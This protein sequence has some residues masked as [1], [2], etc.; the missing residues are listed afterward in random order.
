MTKNGPKAI[1]LLKVF[2]PNPIKIIP[3]MAPI[4]KASVKA[5]A[6]DKGFKNKEIKTASLASPRPIALTE[7]KK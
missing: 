3:N 4:I 2:L 5:I 1:W 6:V 7:E